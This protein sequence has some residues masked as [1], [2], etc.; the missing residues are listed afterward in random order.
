MFYTVYQ[1]K[2][3]VNGKLYIG[4]HKTDNLEDGYFGSG[5]L[6]KAAIAKY[7]LEN[8]TKKYLAIFDNPEEMFSM[9]AELVDDEFLLRED[10]YNL[11][12]GGDGGWDHIDCAKRN[13]IQNKANIDYDDPEY[14][15]KLSVAAKRSNRRRIEAGEK[16]F[17]GKNG[18]AG[19]SHS[20]ESRQKMSRSKSGKVSSTKGRCWVH[21]LDLKKAKMIQPEEREKYLSKGWLL[22]NKR[23]FP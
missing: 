13:K 2:N 20:K 10:T 23:K 16:M 14:K 19:K 3:T 21:N 15:K 9:E 6:L 12:R 1:I 8:F 4:V 17:G 22:G 5:K 7:G 11:K 18:F